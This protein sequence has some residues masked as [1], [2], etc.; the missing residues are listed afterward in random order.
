MKTIARC[1]LC[2]NE[3]E[4]EADWDGH[5]VG[6]P[7]CASNTRVRIPP[8]I[9]PN[10]RACQDCGHMIGKSAERCPQC[11]GKNK[12]GTSPVG[13][14]VALLVVVMLVSFY[15]SESEKAAAENGRTEPKSVVDA[16]VNL[17]GGHSL[18]IR[19]LNPFPWESATIYLNGVLMGY[20][21]QQG[22]LQPRES[23]TI[24]LSEFVKSNG[25]R[26]QPQLKRPTEVIVRVP[27]CD[28]PVYKF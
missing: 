26:F 7:W 6:C 19:N 10:V 8:K 23:V 27:G 15:G 16:S 1:E 20:E 28:S 14:F 21:Y 11:G 2:N 24:R 17:L 12:R 9:A 25:D 22:S 3:I 4:V 5:E 18:V 13:V